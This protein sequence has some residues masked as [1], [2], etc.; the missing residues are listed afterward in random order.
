M[1]VFMKKILCVLFT[2]LSFTEVLHSDIIWTSPTA[3]STSLTDASDPHVVV[4]SNGNATAVWVENSVIKASSLP[5]GG[6]WGAP[7]TL[8]NILNTALDPKIAVDGS[9]N[10]TALWIENTQIESANLPFGGSWTA[11]TS[12][13]SG[14]GATTPVLA[15]DSSG[16]AVAIWERSGFIE[17]STRISGTWSLV[18]VLSS[19]NSSNPH[20]AISSFGTAIAAWHS[21]VSGL[22][23]IVTDILTIS[24]NTWAAT[25]NVFTA[26]A[27][28]FHNYPKIAIDSNGNASV[29]WYRYNLL[30]VNSFENVQFLASSLPQGASAWTTPTVLSV[31]GI[32]NPADLSAN[33]SYDV[34]GNVLAVWTNSFDGLNFS[35]ESSQK[36]FGAPWKRPID[37]QPP[38]LYSFAFDLSVAS[39]TALLTNMAWDG[40]STLLIQSQES[41]ITD[42]VIQG[43]T[44]TSPFSSGN[45]NGFPACSLSL[46]GS[47]FNAVAVWIHFDGTNNVIHASTGSESVISPP[48]SVSASQSS[49]SFGV[50]TDYFNTITWSGSPDPNIIQ[51]NIYRNGIFFASTAD[52]S[53]FTFDDHNQIQGGTVVYGVAALTSE[54]RQSAI[55]SFTLFP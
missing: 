49:V 35:M 30:N 9:G 7:V 29:A 8:S 36:L 28:Y 13:I 24:G 32:R 17:S 46:T 54:F 12:P 33:I 37:L 55:I 22:D 40:I 25:K 4:D 10:I 2:L 42:P 5:F 27:D 53:T 41:D 20:I 15:V 6:S 19:S 16:N 52:A 26:T 38:S 48:S 50:Y 47:T 51:Y 1:M 11:E 39:G 34:S 31:P 14:S 3:I 44:I 43:W 23:V 45:D 21:I 18:S